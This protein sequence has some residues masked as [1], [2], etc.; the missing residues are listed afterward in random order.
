MIHLNHSHAQDIAIMQYQKMCKAGQI[1]AEEVQNAQHQLECIIASLQNVSIINP[2]ATLIELPEDIAHPRKSLLLLLNFIE[3]ITFFFQYQREQT[4]DKATG[5][6]LIQTAPEDIELAF[7]LLKNSLFRRADELSTTARGFYNWLTNFL[8][9]AKTAQF[10][11]LDIRKAKAIHPRTLNRYLQ[12][13]RTYS[14]IK[15]TGGNKHREGYIYKLT[16]FGNQSD[17]QN[18]IEKALQDNLGKIKK[19]HA[20][21]KG[22]LAHRSD[23]VGETVSQKALSN[24]QNLATPAN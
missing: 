13:L 8:E 17:V 15:V 19:E 16:E 23:S 3:V 7:N 21:Q 14:Y 4:A 18:R 22:K 5:E 2:F 12:E 1:K 6:V 20:K 9:Q 10:T 24:S 11:A